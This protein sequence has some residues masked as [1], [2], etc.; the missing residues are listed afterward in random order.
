MRERRGVDAVMLDILT[1][2]R[3]REAVVMLTRDAE[4]LTLVDCGRIFIFEREREPDCDVMERREEVRVD[5]M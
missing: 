1:L 5:A 4:I 3:V 2:F